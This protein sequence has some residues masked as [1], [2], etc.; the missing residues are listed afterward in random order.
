MAKDK[1]LFFPILNSECSPIE[2]PSVRSDEELK[3]CAKTFQDMAKG[4]KASLDGK[5]LP[6]IRI[7]TG[8]F[9]FRLTGNN[10]FGT[11]AP[12]ESHSTNDGHFSYGASLTPGNHIL[13]F[14]GSTTPTSTSLNDFRQENVLQNYCFSIIGKSLPI[15]F[16]LEI[17][18]KKLI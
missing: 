10:I 17:M 5:P 2:Y 13:K 9:N 8:I 4:L 7:V 16:N 12:M 1:P 3:N 14:S 11:G 6:V 15:L 18:N